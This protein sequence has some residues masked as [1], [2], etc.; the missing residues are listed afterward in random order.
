MLW[1]FSFVHELLCMC[2]GVMSWLDS[3]RNKHMSVGV[4]ATNGIATK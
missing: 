2:L 4:H 1:D 3:L